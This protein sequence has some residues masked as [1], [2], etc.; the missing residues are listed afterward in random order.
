[1]YQCGHFWQCNYSVLDC[2]HVVGADSFPFILLCLCEHLQIWRF[3]VSEVAV[4][5]CLMKWLLTMYDVC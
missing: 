1:M 3:L 2:T 5:L 4:F